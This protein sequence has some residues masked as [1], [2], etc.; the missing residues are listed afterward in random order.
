[1]LDELKET[2][3]PALTALEERVEIDE[4]IEMLTGNLEKITEHGNVA[5]ISSRACWSIRV[6]AVTNA[7]VWISTD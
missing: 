7:E 6:A 1:L 2:T 4:T 5:T 3:A